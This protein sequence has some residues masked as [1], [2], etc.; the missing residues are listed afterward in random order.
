MKS[1]VIGSSGTVICGLRLYSSFGATLNKIV[2]LITM[3]NDDI[4]FYLLFVSVP[5][6]TSQENQYD[7]PL[8]IQNAEIHHLLS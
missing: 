7:T 3:F 5:R 2:D 1:R 4:F 6:F 8:S